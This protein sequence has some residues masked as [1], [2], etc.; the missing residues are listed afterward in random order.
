RVPSPVLAPRLRRPERAGHEHDEAESD[1][2]FRASLGKSV[3][4]IGRRKKVSGRTEETGTGSDVHPVRRGDVEVE[5]LLHDA[6]R[7]LDRRAEKNQVDVEDDG[8]RRQP[9]KD[10]EDDVGVLSR[11]AHLSASM[12]RFLPMTASKRQT[13]AKERTMT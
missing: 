10:V 5:D 1:G 9:E 6:H 4:S 12:A 13:C 3:A 2:R 7:Q 11:R 8:K